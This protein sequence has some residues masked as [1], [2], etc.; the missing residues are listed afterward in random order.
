MGPHPESLSYH[1]E[2]S[3][4]DIISS[5]RRQN[6]DLRAQLVKVERRS[7]ARESMS[8]AASNRT[9]ESVENSQLQILCDQESKE[10][11]KTISRL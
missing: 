4:D 11:R 2:F 1:R 7:K 3:G 6:D 5:L 8:A 9:R 10:L